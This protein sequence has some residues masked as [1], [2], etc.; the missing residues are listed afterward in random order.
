[1]SVVN[2]HFGLFEID[3]NDFPT[4]I[5]LQS[6]DAQQLQIDAN[7][8]CR[9]MPTQL[10]YFVVIY[11]IEKRERSAVWCGRSIR[12]QAAHFG[13]PVWRRWQAWVVTDNNCS[14]FLI[15]D[16]LLKSKLNFILPA[17]CK[18]VRCFLLQ[19]QFDRNYFLFSWNDFFEEVIEQQQ[20]LRKNDLRLCR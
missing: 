15:F 13:C 14:G 11:S 20:T 6:D 12:H 18:V 9:L 5:V 3:G 17:N 4:R 19:T 1:M 8:L 16:N 10:N 2:T 7:A